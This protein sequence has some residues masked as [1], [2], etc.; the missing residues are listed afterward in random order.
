MICDLL[1][2]ICKKMSVFAVAITVII[3]GTVYFL[4]WKR[5]SMAMDVLKLKGKFQTCLQR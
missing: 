2:D 3:K 1:Y 5:P 4:D